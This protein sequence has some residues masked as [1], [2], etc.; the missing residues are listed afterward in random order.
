MAS[1]S[2]ANPSGSAAPTA[3]LSVP[4]ANATVAIQAQDITATPLADQWIGTI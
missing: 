1:I 3:T 2:T 4:G